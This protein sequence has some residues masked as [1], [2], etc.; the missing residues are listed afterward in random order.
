MCLPQVHK[1]YYC[2]TRHVHKSVSTSSPN[3][4]QQQQSVAQSQSPTVGQQLSPTEKSGYNMVLKQ[5]LYAAISTSPLILVP[6]S[7]VAGAGG[8]SP[9]LVP[10]GNIVIPNPRASSPDPQ[11]SVIPTFT[12][13]PDA[14]KKEEKPTEESTPKPQKPDGAKSPAGD[15][16]TDSEQPLDLSFRKKISDGTKKLITHR[17]IESGEVHFC[18]SK[19]R[20]WN[21]FQLMK[22]CCA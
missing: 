20:N 11:K 14:S 5:P 22:R 19:T 10:T 13:L 16:R 8:L 12:V 3:T 15:S 18:K 1:E 7:Y 21:V 9:S 4:A 6:C 17:T 2:N